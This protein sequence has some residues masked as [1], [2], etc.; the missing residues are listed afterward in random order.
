MRNLLCLHVETLA[1]SN[2]VITPAASRPQT[3][4][5]PVVETTAAP[6]V[7]TTA[8]PVVK[9]TAAPVVETTA[10]LVVE[11]TAAPVVE[12]TAAPVVEST[13]APVVET[14]AAP[15]VETT[16]APVVETT[17][18]PVV[19]TTA[20]P[21]V[22]TTAAP[23]VKTTAAPVVE[24]TAAPVVET[25]AAPVVETTSSTASK[26]STDIVTRSTLEVV[27]S[28]PMSI[29]CL[30]HIMLV[31]IDKSHLPGFNLDSLRLF[32]P[33]CKPGENGT[34]VLIG[35]PLNGCGTRRRYLNSAVVYSNRVKSRV[36]ASTRGISRSKKLDVPFSCVYPT[37]Q[38]VSSFGF[39]L[40]QVIPKLVKEERG[41]GNFEVRVDLYTDDTFTRPLNDASYPLEV[42]VQDRVYFELN[43]D[44][45]DPRLKV[46]AENCSATPSQNRNDPRRYWLIQNGCKLDETLEYHAPGV[47]SQRMSFEAFTFVG[48]EDSV[49]YL[50]CD[51]VICDAND[52]NSRCNAGCLP[53]ARRRRAPIIISTHNKA[54]GNI[55]SGPMLVTHK[56]LRRPRR[57][58]QI[59]NSNLAVVKTQ[60]TP[61]AIS[62]SGVAVVSF[63]ALLLI[64]VVAVV[65]LFGYRSLKK[66][67]ENTAV[68][69]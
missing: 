35:V 14:T 36:V 40:K 38:S 33:M 49:A 9:T 2:V 60:L 15:V 68:F 28:C 6:V 56:K 48:A 54:S 47:N 63:G 59:S 21:D 51:V 5:A 65:S 25:T 52:P 46:F 8:A 34:H 32:D 64:V 62:K 45:T 67:T 11:T 27:D 29:T 10:A 18:A 30:S 16:A 13:A 58:V 57:E 42:E 19:E 3:T 53:S 1:G 43:I 69:L 41:F 39:Q 12:T 31:S 17:A 44:T 24:T 37:S 23:V 26:P 66:R 20:A 50:Q 61:R 7:E 4:A 55:R 22:E